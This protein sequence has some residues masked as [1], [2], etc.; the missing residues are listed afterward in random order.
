[1]K[2]IQ[3]IGP[4]EL[5]AIAS[6]ITFSVAQTFLRQGMRSVSP[7]AAALIVNGIVSLGG[8]ILSLWNGTLF[9]SKAETLF[10]YAAVGAAGP[11]IGRYCYLVGVSRIGLSR[12]VPISSAAPIWGTLFAIL[13][14]GETPT[15][16][17]LLGTLGIVIG[18]SILGIQDDK[19]QSFKSWFQGALIFPLV[20]SLAYAIAPIFAKLAYTHQ[21]TPSVGMAVSFATA[22]CLLLLTKPILPGQNDIRG[23]KK[24]PPMG[25]RR[26]RHR[27][28]QFVYALD[29]IYDGERIHRSALE[30]DRT[31]LGTDSELFFP[32]QARNNQPENSSGHDLRRH[33]RSTNHRLQELTLKRSNT[34]DFSLDLES[35]APRRNPIC[36]QP[37]RPREGNTRDHPPAADLQ[38]SLPP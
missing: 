11:T 1:M 25:R 3:L 6:S 10:W 33:R 7:L 21:M 4:G 5:L 13:L 27:H 30:P 34:P 36:L 29:G 20:A 2:W 8:F 16:M 18:V 9:T 31:D 38:G 37:P 26:G 12:T 24:R 28:L 17:V 19:S 35:P 22:N 14:L 32:G 15:T 23:K